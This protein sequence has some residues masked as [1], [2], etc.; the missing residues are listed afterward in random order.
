MILIFACALSTAVVSASTFSF[1]FDLWSIK[2][3][4]LEDDF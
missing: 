1:I 4:I 3:D 2:S